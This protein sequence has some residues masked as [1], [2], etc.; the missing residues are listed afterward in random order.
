MTKHLP[1][2]SFILHLTTPPTASSTSCLFPP[3][4]YTLVLRLPASE[5]KLD[6]SFYLLPAKPNFPLRPVLCMSLLA[7]I[8]LSIF[9]PSSCCVVCDTVARLRSE[10]CKSIFKVLP[11]PWKQHLTHQPH[12]KVHLE[13]ILELLI[14]THKS[15]KSKM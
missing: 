11:W 14:I 6:F 2:V 5:V 7:S 4:P 10:Q 1:P 15:H 8:L 3:H 12:L 9:P 13:A